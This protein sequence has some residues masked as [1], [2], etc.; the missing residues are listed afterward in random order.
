MTR[1]PRL[2][3]KGH[4]QAVINGAALLVLGSALIHLALV[5]PH[6]QEYT[7]FGLLFIAAAVAQAALAVAI[8]TI[9]SPRL[10]AAGLI[11]TLALMAAWV[12]SR[13][14]G[15][16]IGPEPWRPE[17]IGFADITCVTLELIT[18][19]VLLRLLIKPRRPRVRSA[20]RVILGTVPAFVLVSLLTAVGVG[21]A[22]SGMP[23]AFNASPGIPGLPSLSLETLR[24][25]AGTDP[26]RS[27]TLT[28]ET[29][30]V[31]GQT[32]WTYNGTVPGP[33]LRVT[34]GDRVRVTLVNHLPV[35]TTIHWHGIRIPNAEDGVA[36]IT[37]NAV[38]PGGTYTYEFVAQ[39]A[40][41]FWYHSHQ[42][43]GT[44]LTQGLFGAIIVEPAAGR[45]AETRDDT[46][47]LHT[48]VGSGTVAVN[49][50]P[51]GDLRLAARPGDTVRLRL[52]NAVAPGM[53]GGPET[54]VLLGASYRVVAL[55]GHDLNQPELLGLQRLA[56][57]MGQRADIVF[58]MPS[59]GAVRLVDRALMG[60]ANFISGAFGKL[61]T[62][63]TVTIGEGPLPAGIDPASLPLFDMTGYGSP[64]DDP[65]AAGP[66]DK[67][68][69]IV[70]NEGPGF[71][72]GRIELVHSINGQASPTVP[73]IIV[74]S[75]ELVRLHVVNDTGEFHPMHL[76]GHIFSVLAKNGQAITGSP[77]HLDT[78]L[79]G[80]HETWEV[81]FKADNPGI[82][83]LHC[84][85]LL[86][87]SFGMSMT[88]NYAGITTP[89]EMGSRSGN[90]PE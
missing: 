29:V 63:E 74:G 31:N 80:P 79:V 11:G 44:Q 45:V 56:L 59:S 3:Y 34:Q 76:H 52:I 65:V 83:M 17:H 88:I 22:T 39:D 14:T 51:G 58:T 49:G 13:T 90:M 32:A 7:L 78:L 9:P 41:T 61:K 12:V 33:E 46:V 5:P 47:I 2:A 87:A 60:E 15:L 10:F 82:W 53:D 23:Y 6:L 70:L 28:A 57:G 68:Y 40:G 27:F 24:G 42:D 69:P 25:T 16:P 84:H 50:V 21:A 43:T 73:P 71:H 54:P 77:I 55:D 1:Q 85:V 89:F 35:S 18:V 66:F 4:S 62:T 72:D 36:G 26:V 8:L 86:H 67:T 38:A 75:G 30:P 19:L 20:R 37:Q 48:V 81:A 64:A